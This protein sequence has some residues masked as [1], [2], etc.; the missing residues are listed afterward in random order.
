MIVSESVEFSDKHSFT[1]YPS[2]DPYRWTARQTET[3]CTCYVWAG[4][5][6]FQLCCCVSLLVVAEIVLGDTY[7]P[8][9]LCRCVFFCVVAGNSF[10][11]HRLVF[12]LRREKDLGFTSLPTI[13][14]VPLCQFLVAAGNG[15][16]LL[17]F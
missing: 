5:K 11:L 13:P 16:W 7:L 10:W 2:L 14:V 6:F 12:W 1:L 9:Q 3:E 8:Y 15:F 4:G 17:S